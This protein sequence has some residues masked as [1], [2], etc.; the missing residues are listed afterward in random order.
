MQQS[1]VDGYIKH[2]LDD[3]SDAR[4]KVFSGLVENH[5]PNKLPEYLF[6]SYFLP[7]FMGKNP[8]QKWLL[9]WVSIAGSPSAEVSIIDQAGMELFRVPAVL[10]TQNL[11]LNNSNA[12]LADIFAH[13]KI[14]A[15]TLAGNNQFLFSELDKKSQELS[16]SL[17]HDTQSRWG[18]IF[19]R[20]N[21][22][23]DNQPQ[24]AAQQPSQEDFFDY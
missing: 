22:V 10:P 13:S 23:P 19:A 6:T 5:Q 12:T 11:I 21:I 24:T 17:N 1:Q 8:N 14:L 2:Y 18:A 20:Y 9:E 3:L 7:G 4:D 15:N 16:A